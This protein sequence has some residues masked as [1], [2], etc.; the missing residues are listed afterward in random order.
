MPNQTQR[1]RYIDNL[2]HGLSHSEGKLLSIKKLI[3]ELNLQRES[4]E[5]E[6]ATIESQIEEFYNE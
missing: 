4:L 5:R 6:I 3:V 1:E 2:G